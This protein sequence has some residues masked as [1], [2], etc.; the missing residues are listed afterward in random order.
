M[1]KLEKAVVE[2][3]RVF[4]KKIE[5]LQKKRFIRWKQAEKLQLMLDKAEKKIKKLTKN[6]AR[7]QELL[8]LANKEKLTK[9]EKE[10]KETLNKEHESEKPVK[11]T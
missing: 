4:T 10:K 9:S 6:N 2:A 5:K 3:K 1:V 8:D 7:L 11:E